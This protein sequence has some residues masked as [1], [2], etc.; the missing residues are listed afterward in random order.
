[1]LPYVL[2][3]GKGNLQYCTSDVFVYFIFRHLQFES[4]LRPDIRYKKYF[5]YLRFLIANKNVTSKSRI[6]NDTLE[7]GT[8]N[9]S[10]CQNFGLVFLALT[11][12]LC[13]LALTVPAPL[14][15]PTQAW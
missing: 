1:M 10:L 6:L 4:K 15:G 11:S 7:V 14:T 13:D 3:T 12:M 8:W 9:Q 2:N 5:F